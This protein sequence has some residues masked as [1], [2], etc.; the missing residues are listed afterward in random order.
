MFA[1]RVGPLSVRCAR[2][3]SYYPR[4]RPFGRGSRL[5]RAA[6]R[7][8]TYRLCGP[9]VLSVNRC[10]QPIVPPRVTG[11]SSRHAAG[12]SAVGLACVGSP[13][14][15]SLL[16][17]G[18]RSSGWRGYAGIG[19]AEPA[20][21]I[22]GTYFRIIRPGEIFGASFSLGKIFG[23]V[24]WGIFAVLKIFRR[25]IF[26]NICYLLQG[27]GEV[28]ANNLPFVCCERDEES[29]SGQNLRRP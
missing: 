14:S 25:N 11:R 5:L 22:A 20:E 16:S 9:P 19:V 26:W 23:A 24:V 12:T 1:Y 8:A 6:V 18:R 3:A 21:N 17:A 10:S 29:V 28:F 13:C 2:L 4:R 27:G 7:V 15:T